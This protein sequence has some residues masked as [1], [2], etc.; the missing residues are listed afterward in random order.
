MHCSVF[1]THLGNNCDIYPVAVP[2]RAPVSA[3]GQATIAKEEVHRLQAE[4]QTLKDEL[5]SI[6]SQ[7]ANTANLHR[8]AHV[9]TTYT[10]ALLHIN[11]TFSILYVSKCCCVLVAPCTP[12][13]DCPR[14]T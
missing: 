10:A 2:D 6:H 1:H 11:C 3:A 8:A 5:Q 13:K 12:G 14:S 4:L 9:C 7:Y